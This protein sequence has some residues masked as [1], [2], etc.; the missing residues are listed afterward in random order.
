MTKAELEHLK[1][2]LKKENNLD[3][4][5]QKIIEQIET[6]EKSI[7]FVKLVKACKIN[8]GIKIISIEKQKELTDLFQ[9]ALN[10][11]RVMKFVP[12]SGAATRM[13]K[14]LQ[15]VLLDNKNVTIK[16]LK[17]KAKDENASISVEFLENINRF[18]FYDDLKECLQKDEKNI[19]G[20]FEMG[21]VTDVLVYTLNKEGLNY[22]N[23][24]KGCVKFH[25]YPD[26][27][28]TA[29]EEHLV[30]A[31][32]YAADKNK[33]AVI[34]F[35]ISLEH[36]KSIKELT[37]SIEKKYNG[38][39]WRIDGSFSF[40]S[41]STNTIAV[42]PNNK[43][44]KDSNGKIVFR[45]GGHGALLKN[46]NELNG[47]IILIKNI[48]NVVPDHLKGETYKYKKILGGYLV[49]IQDKIFSYLNKIE[50]ENIDKSLNEEIQKYIS[51]ELELHLKPDF[52]SLNNSEKKKY[53]FDYLNRPIR[54]CG[55]VKK[56][57]HEGG[58]PF[59][60]EDENGYISKQ[61]VETT[62]IDMNNP[63]Q[64]NIFEDATH[65]S[66]VDFA[67]GV[68]D[69][70][71]NNFNLQDFTNPNTGLITKKSKEGRELKALELPGLWNGGMYNWI[72]VF[73]EVPLIT[74][75]PVKEVND[76]LLPEHQPTS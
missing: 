19:N 73:V 64:R 56:E 66:P 52:D 50:K 23:L 62:Q 42:T 45:P 22:A 9:N 7:P 34:H 35:T 29:F 17:N 20:L 26:G 8:D 24:P 31:M 58:G 40:Q 53:L 59:W 13:F 70:K 33:N 15:A 57:G 4:N 30:E 32:N 12:A 18:A 55:I 44:F 51:T 46:L 61:V 72:T 63:A 68:K 60:V 65:F 27:S 21:D 76:L 14:K 6:F 74:F 37:A 36:E 41:P 71:G 2:V 48:D 5:P 16:E 47:D 10:N 3:I 69:F 39:G 38:D 43:L 1:N 28:R 25:Y 75:N 67:C 54:V 11:G 49:E